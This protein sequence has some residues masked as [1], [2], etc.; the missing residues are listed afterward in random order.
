MGLLVFAQTAQ[1]FDRW[2]NNEHQEGKAPSASDVL[3]GRE[4]FERGPCA[5]CH[6][7][8]GTLAGARV[9]PDL[10]H[11]GARQTLAAGLM[12][13]TSDNMAAWLKDPQQFKPGAKMP[14]TGLSDEELRA[15]VAYM[16]S[17]K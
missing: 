2:L 15:L 3:L 7:I 13:N 4:I 9:G 10:T 12:S 14:A 1:D 5:M 6:A 16:E 11:I 17:L 8:Q